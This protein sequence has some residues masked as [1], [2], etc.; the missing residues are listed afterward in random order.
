[1]ATSL[2][3]DHIAPVTGIRTPAAQRVLDS[4]LD[5]FYERG[6]RSTSVR[7]VMAA[8]HLTSGAFY[9]HFS[10]KDAL[11]YQIATTTHDLCDQYLYRAL[12]TSTEPRAQLWNL[13]FAIAEFHAEH[14]KEARV[15]SQDFRELPERELN[16]IRQRRRQVR[17]MFEH[18]LTAG[19]EAGAF[20][21]PRLGDGRAIRLLATTITN[22][23]IR[24]AEWFSPDDGLSAKEIAA[25][26][27]DIALRMTRSNGE[28]EFAV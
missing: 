6:F 26:H 22:M 10:S 25:F 28:S 23:A 11:L 7:D 16:E 15:T 2:S 14:A 27:G 21:S 9:N 24:I 4:A 8:C 13:T 17:A 3:N 12:S 5:L 1:M 19:V 18:V 20:E